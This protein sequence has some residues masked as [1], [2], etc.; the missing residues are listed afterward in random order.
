LGIEK[1]CLVV[2]PENSLCTFSDWPFAPYITIMLGIEQY[3]LVIK[4]GDLRYTYGPSAGGSVETGSVDWCSAGTD[5]DRISPSPSD[6]IILLCMIMLCNI[7]WY[8]KVER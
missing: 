4:P 3:G 2:R 5:G 1:Y 6:V 8:S 7:R